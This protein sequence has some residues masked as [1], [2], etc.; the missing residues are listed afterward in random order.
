M[1]WMNKEMETKQVP[2]E[3]PDV[4]TAVIWFPGRLVLVASVYV[5]G[6]DTEALKHV[7]LL[8]K[9]GYRCTA[10]CRH[11]CGNRNCRGLQST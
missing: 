5:A 9:N 8:A 11:N 2:I 3:S 4:T 7:C 1:L 10:K 6:G